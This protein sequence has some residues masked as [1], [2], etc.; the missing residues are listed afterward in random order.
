MA[1][2]EGQPDEALLGHDSSGDNEVVLKDTFG[3]L[4]AANAVLFSAQD[5]SGHI[6]LI[7]F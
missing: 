1:L 4:A 3:A 2:S 7:V 6:W 5:N